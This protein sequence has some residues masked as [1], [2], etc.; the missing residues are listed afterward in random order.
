M[1]N[2]IVL[3]YCYVMT[4]VIFYVIAICNIF[5][6]YFY[7][8]YSVGRFSSCCNSTNRTK[9]EKSELAFSEVSGL[10]S[11]INNIA[12]FIFCIVSFNFKRVLSYFFYDILWVLFIPKLTMEFALSNLIP[13]ATPL[14]I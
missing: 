7:K 8:P 10:L 2:Q 13:L 6:T 14:I 1:A 11:S 4:I 3:S 9:K 12:N 5:I